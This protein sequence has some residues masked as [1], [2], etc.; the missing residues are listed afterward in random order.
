M[1]ARSLALL[2]SLA[3][4]A[5]APAADRPAVVI[6][7]GSNQSFRAALQRFATPDDAR[8]E[9]FRDA[10]A[11]ALEFSD[12]FQVLDR[13]AFLG[14]TVTR[15]PGGEDVVCSDWTPIGADAL[16]GGAMRL[17]PRELAVEFHVWDTARCQSLV[18]KRYR[19]AADADPAAIARRIADDV[20]EAFLGVRGVAATELAFISTRGGNP[21]V[22]VM[23]ADGSNARPATANRSLNAFPSWSPSGDAIL[24]TSYRYRNRPHLFLT[25]RAGARPGRVLP[26]L[27]GSLSQFRGTFDPSGRKLAVVLSGKSAAEIFTVNANGSGLVRLT[28]HPAIDISPS[29]SPD[30]RR[31]AFVSDRSGAPQVYVM[32][33]D[34]RDVRRLTFEGT[35]NTHPAW[36]PDGR[37][38]AYES[39]VGASFDIWLI[40]VESGQAWPLIDHPRSDEA[41]SWAPNSRKIAFTSTRRGRPD[42]YVVDVGGSQVRQITQGAGENRSPAWGPFPR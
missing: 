7:P 12:A 41:P 31:I 13:K 21:E 11:A 25:S 18:R 40:D 28:N 35:Y 3:L 30:G 1:G 4:A 22:W 19:Q 8:A 38:I 26:E 2:A 36:S 6:T 27:N 15:S 42:V 17:D 14:P 10:L 33:A 24:Y 29:W 32:Q 34:G 16:V 37:Y 5:P 9:R 39:R 20:V 23:N